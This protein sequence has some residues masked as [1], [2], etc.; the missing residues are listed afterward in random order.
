[1]CSWLG[2]QAWEAFTS[3]TPAAVA[4]GS[5]A[6]AD[7]LEASPAP[8]PPALCVAAAGVSSSG[9]GKASASDPKRSQLAI[10]SAAFNSILLVRQRLLG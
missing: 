9:S 10:E 6:V 8:N 5:A 1:M 4:E 3:G 2:V 7:V